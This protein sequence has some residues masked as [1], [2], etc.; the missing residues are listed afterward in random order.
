MTVPL[1]P[2][3]F[4]AASINDRR[5]RIESLIAQ[6][7]QVRSSFEPHWR[8]CAE[9]VKPRR[10][11]FFVQDV[12]KG[13]RRNSKIID[14]TATF[15]ART[16][17]S[18]M[19]AGIT[20]PA[21]PW[22]R[23]STQDPA[24]AEQADVKEW[25]HVVTT[26]M[27]GVFIRS[28][29]YNSLPIVYSDLGIFGTAAMAVVEDDESVIRTVPHP[30]GSYWIANDEKGRV[31]VWARNFTMTVR[32]ILEK[33]CQDPESHQLTDLSKLSIST[34]N[35]VTANQLEQPVEIWHCIYPNPLY[36]G[37]KE[38]TKY[39]RFASVYFESGARPEGDR[40]FLAEEGY[41]EF[42][43]LCPRWET[44]G[45]DAY[46]TDC[47]AMTVLGDI[48]QLQTGERRGLQ[49]IEKKVNPPLQ[50]PSELKTTRP[51][52]LP[53]E[54]TYH[55]ARGNNDGMRAIHEVQL[56]IEELEL[57]QQQVRQ[58]ISRGFYEDLFLMLAQT[59][60]R[61]ITAREIEERHEEKLL[62]LGPVL[63]QLN[64]DLL[65]PLIDRTFAIMVR[66]GLIPPPPEALQGLELKVEYISIM[67]Q[68]QKM[69]G[70]SGLE[71]FI[72][73]ATTLS[74][75][76]QRPEL[77]DKIDLD[78]SIDEYAEM[79]GISPRIVVPDARVAEIRAGRAEMQAEAEQAALAREQAATMKDLAGAKTTE[80]SALTDLLGMG[81]TPG[82]IP[83]PVM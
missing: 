50:A 55:D 5:V 67:A 57:K 41:D 8:E 31:R 30:V 64:Q 33:W 20:S 37:V 68:A 78:Q 16:M 61:Q 65:D 39:K 53:G 83:A 15:A 51:S 60:R 40:T 63:E 79:T 9:F 36:D 2:V 28:N 4:A 11:R 10:T 21:R 12:N 23:L 34:R 43:N 75:N 19:M 77:L 6:M 7:K 25:L 74:V 82:Q 49:A 27:Q 69:I 58:R 73:Y 45:E 24:L 26:R 70:I 66:R 80:P 38:T 46:G 22:F 17:S 48:K 35:L 14:S 72:G 56:G 54:I 59:D 47:P 71:R 29:L 3:P 62:A 42:P 44:V 13:D 18:G 1:Q 76:T 52:I 32:Q 81:G